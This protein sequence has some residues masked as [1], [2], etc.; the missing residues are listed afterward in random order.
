MNY[1]LKDIPGFEGKYA[2]TTDGRIW[3][4]R[5]GIFLKGGLMPRGY[6]RVMLGRKDWGLVH[7]LVAMTFIANPSNLPQVNHI[8]GKH[9]DNRVDNLEWVDNKTNMEHNLKLNGRYNRA[10][11]TPE[12]VKAIRDEYST[13]LVY[14]KELA[15]QYG[16]TQAQVHSI[17][18]NKSWAHLT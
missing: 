7:R 16:I 17:T 12:Q 6:M 1:K 3:S 18:S 9:A 2:A 13:G 5:R 4:H 10:F 15:K 11:L 8:N 14:Q